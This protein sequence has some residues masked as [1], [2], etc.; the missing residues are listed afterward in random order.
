MEQQFC[1]LVDCGHFGYEKLVRIGDEQHDYACILG[2]TGTLKAIM[3][4]PDGGETE[5][6]KI[7]DKF[8]RREAIRE[9]NRSRELKT[10][11]CTYVPTVYAQ[12]KGT[13]I[14]TEKSSKGAI[15][16]VKH[17]EEFYQTI[18]AEIQSCTKDSN[19]ELKVSRAVLVVFETSQELH[20]CADNR[21]LE[22]F[23]GVIQKLTPEISDEMVKKNIIEQASFP[24]KV[25]FMTRE[26]GRGTDF[27]GTNKEMNE[28]G[29]VR[30]SL[31]SAYN[32]LLCFAGSCYSNIPQR[33][34]Y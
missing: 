23:K 11:Q 4:D 19:S 15:W 14:F 1:L 7:L 33:R 34:L 29:G 16:F 24:G 28:C 30:S 20:Q 13:L 18:L 25:T 22:P 21:A 2:V 17:Y 6:R 5:Q 32:F 3:D 27:K 12:A 10:L 9:A 26:F 8:C 31:C